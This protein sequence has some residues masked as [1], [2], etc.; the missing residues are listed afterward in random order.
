MLEELGKPTGKILARRRINDKRLCAYKILVSKDAFS[1]SSVDFPDSVFGSLLVVRL[2]RILTI[3]SADMHG[4]SWGFQDNTTTY[5]TGTLCIEEGSI[6][7]DV[8]GITP[9]HFRFGVELC[10]LIVAI[11]DS[12]VPGLRSCFALTQYLPSPCCHGMEW[13]LEVLRYSKSWTCSCGMMFLTSELMPCFMEQCAV[14]PTFVTQRYQMPG[15]VCFLSV[16]LS[17]FLFS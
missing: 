7:L 13:K 12:V 3:T 16:C 8:D 11:L 10:K 14:D 17:S 15:G 5:A 2:A 4:C 9:W 1:S 6:S